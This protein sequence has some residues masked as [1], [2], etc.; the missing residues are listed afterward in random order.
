MT[1]QVE[2]LQFL[3]YNPSSSRAEIAEALFA[4]L[5][6]IKFLCAGISLALAVRQ[7][8]SIRAAERG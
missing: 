7:A 5:G 2:I 1:I 4:P 8:L 3:H 6:V